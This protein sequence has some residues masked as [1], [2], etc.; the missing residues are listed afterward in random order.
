MRRIVVVGTSGSGKTTLARTLAAALRV[1]HVELDA[2]Y[3][4]PDWTPHPAE[5]FAQRVER[6][7][8]GDAWVVDGG[9]AAV[10]D[11]IWARADTIVWLD[12]PM[13]VVFPRAL[14]RCVARAVT[15][16]PLWAGNR[17]SLRLTF[18]SRDSLL[19]WVIAT[20]RLRRRDYPKLLKAPAWRHLHVQRHRSPAETQRWVRT[21]E[22]AELLS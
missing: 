14:C 13:S 7:V 8:A 6:A 5:Q 20:W 21:L 11:R 15:R 4:G 19:L 3:W 17:E 18:A 10:R 16:E 9:Y 22:P 1:P 2:L 12:Y